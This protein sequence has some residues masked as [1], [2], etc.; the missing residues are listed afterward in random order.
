[1]SQDRSGSSDPKIS[2]FSRE[3]LKNLPLEMQ[4]GLEPLLSLKDD[5]DYLL[6]FSMEHQHLFEKTWR[7]SDYNKYYDTVYAGCSETTGQC[8]ADIDSD[9]S[10][11]HNSWGDVALKALGERE[12][13]NISTGGASAASIVSS[14]LVHIKKNG[15]P[16][17]ILVLLPHI[18]TRTTMPMD[19]N[20]Y[21]RLHNPSNSEYEFIDNV[22]DIGHSDVKYS[23]RPHYIEEVI[24]PVFVTY[25]NVQA[26]IFLEHI[27]KI[28]GIELA[29]S[30]WSGSTHAIIKSANEAA[31]ALDRAIPFPN[32]FEV[33]YRDVGYGPYHACD[34]LPRDC[35]SELSNH[36]YFRYGRNDHMGT[37]AHAHIAEN[38]IKELTRRSNTATV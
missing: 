18:D 17:R 35:H 11:A 10:E 21:R 1:M 8:L 20:W 25:L 9:F 7:G 14:L 34:S 2:A 19:K 29:Y 12:W 4:S 23:K 24:S 3:L 15:A 27:C 6:T 36:K 30:T 32:Y 26:L 37:H 13:L 38:F 16:K 5:M 28:S 33:D 22:T 31:I